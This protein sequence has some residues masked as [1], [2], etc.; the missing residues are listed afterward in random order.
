MSIPEKEHDCARIVK[1][2]HGIEV[3][4][5]SYVHQIDHSKIADLLSDF[6]KSFIHLHA[7]RIP[8]V[9]KTDAYNTIFLGEDCLI[10][11]PAII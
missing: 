10:D 8:I 1:L 7:S 4:N 9:S 3:W 2:I 6:I 11:L 5:L